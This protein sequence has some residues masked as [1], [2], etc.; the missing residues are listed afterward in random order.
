LEES[1]LGSIE[2]RLKTSDRKPFIYLIS[3]YDNVAYS[4]EQNV[5][6]ARVHGQSM[7]VLARE[8][9]DVLQLGGIQIRHGEETRDWSR[10]S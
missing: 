3:E 1:N 10:V 5:R 2:K 4:V 8:A 9:D 6:I 7:V